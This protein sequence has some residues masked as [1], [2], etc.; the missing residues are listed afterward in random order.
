LGFRFEEPEMQI[1]KRVQT[2]LLLLAKDP[3]ESGLVLF[4]LPLC[5]VEKHQLQDTERHF[6][7]CV[8]SSPVSAPGLNHHYF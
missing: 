8:V 2:P 4:C 6:P 3:E 7:N 5:G 1:E